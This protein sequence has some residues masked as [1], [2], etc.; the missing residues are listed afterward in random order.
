MI[1]TDSCPKKISII[2]DPEQMFVDGTFTALRSIHTG[3]GNGS[4]EIIGAVCLGGILPMLQFVGGTLILGS[5]VNTIYEAHE[6]LNLSSKEKAEAIAKKR[7]NRTVENEIGIQHAEEKLNVAK[8]GLANQYLHGAL[9][10]GLVSVGATSA[11]SPYTASLFGFQPLVSNTAALTAGAALGGV[12][13]LRGGLIIGRSVYHLHYLNQFE[14]EFQSSLKEKKS[15]GVERAVEKTMKL[16]DRIGIGSKALERRAGKLPNQPASLKEK[17]GFLQAVDKGIHAKKLHQTINIFFGAMMILGGL[18]SILAAIFSGGAATP[19]ILIAAAAFYALME[20]FHALFD[21]DA[22]F[23]R[24]Q[25]HLY[26]PSKVI[27]EISR[28]IIPLS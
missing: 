14:K 16:I 4:A 27:Q 2:N 13:V 11:L 24:L 5:A 28:H 23:E 18:T 9:G 7:L 3:I 8:F 19:F 1:I 22:I 21:I 10:T 15:L 12:Y 20:V 17:I 6:E 26:T 25:K